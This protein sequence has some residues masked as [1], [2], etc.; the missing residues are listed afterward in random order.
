MR[1]IGVEL[2]LECR[3]HVFEVSAKRTAYMV[4]FVGDFMGQSWQSRSA[5]RPSQSGH[6]GCT[7]FAR[8]A[9]HGAARCRAIRPVGAWVDA[10][11][12]AQP[13]HRS[14]IGPQYRRRGL[15][16]TGQRRLA[17][18]S[19]GCRHLG[20]QRRRGRGAPTPAR[21]AR[22]TG[23]Q[24]HARLPRRI[25]VSAQR[26]AGL[27]QEG[28]VDRPDRSVANGR[29]ARQTGAVRGTRRVLDA[30]ARRADVG[31]LDRGVR[32]C[33]PCGRTAR[34]GVPR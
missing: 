25:A 30:G 2:G 4:Q 11:T 27:D 34:T 1:S 17:G 9:A 24:P 28:A 8:I 23:P 6:A 18:V 15:R 19:A 5:P 21:G 14:G 31:G 22:D 33:P 32:R 29:C 3:C 13:G 10:S 20:A 26:V 16:R 12:V 7:G